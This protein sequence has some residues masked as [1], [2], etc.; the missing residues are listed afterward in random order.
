MVFHLLQAQR[1]LRRACGWVYAEHPA[2]LAHSFR[3]STDTFAKETFLILH[4][5][6]RWAGRPRVSR[7]EVT[8][9]LV[10]ETHGGVR[11]L[12]RGER[13]WNTIFRHNNPTLIDTI[14]AACFMSESVTPFYLRGFPSFLLTCPVE[15]IRP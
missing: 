8:D 3:R 14:N 9:F 2:A 15:W 12:A 7:R 5:A 11:M 10:P 4:N 6:Q 1:R 13:N